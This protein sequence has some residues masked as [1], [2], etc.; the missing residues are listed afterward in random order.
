MSLKSPPK[1]RVGWRVTAYD[2]RI[3][4]LIAYVFPTVVN[5]NKARIRGVEASAETSLWNIRWRGSLTVQRPENEGTG[6]RLQGRAEQFGSLSATRSWGAWTAGL[7]V[8][9]S[10]DRYDSPNE[11]PA[12][13]LGG[14]ATLDARLRRAPGTRAFPVRPVTARAKFIRFSSAPA[15]TQASDLS[16]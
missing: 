12:S 6:A 10:G 1:A 8:H 2:N 14:Y 16:A 13:R 5:V 11:D 4:D 7:T 3:E 15:L 9:A